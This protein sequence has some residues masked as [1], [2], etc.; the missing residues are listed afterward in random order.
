MEGV[1]EGA[2]HATELIVGSPAVARA[3]R[4][5]SQTGVAAEG[6]TGKRVAAATRP[7][8]QARVATREESEVEAEV[9]RAMK[10]GSALVQASLA[11]LADAERLWERWV[12]K[13]SVVIKGFPSEQQV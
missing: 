2:L 3:Q 6:R 11:H 5:R 7:D 10:E 12:M 4:Q 8:D 1:H 9:S 13:S